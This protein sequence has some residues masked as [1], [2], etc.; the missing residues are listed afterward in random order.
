MIVVIAAV[1]IAVAAAAVVVCIV[2]IGVAVI[3]V[4]KAKRALLVG[5]EGVVVVVVVL[6]DV[7]R[8]SRVMLHVCL[9]VRH[10]VG[11][12][13]LLLLLLRVDAVRAV[14]KRNA[15]IR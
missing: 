15:L 12:L 14:E 9:R 5:H 6:F 11:S 7:N 3:L 4:D 10:M 1:A 2:K 8:R 13:L